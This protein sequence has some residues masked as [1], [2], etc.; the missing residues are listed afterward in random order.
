MLCLDS[1]PQLEGPLRQARKAVGQ[2]GGRRPLDPSFSRDVV[3]ISEWQLNV[4][5]FLLTSLS[6]FCY[7]TGGGG[8]LYL[9]SIFITTYFT[10]EET[11]MNS[12]IQS[13][14][15][16]SSSI[17]LFMIQYPVT[18]HTH[19]KDAVL[20]FKSL[21]LGHIPYCFLKMCA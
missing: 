21:K 11:S 3:R 8:M 7:S 5:Q 13:A 17:F 14:S 1:L 19:G 20:V 6:H 10:N 9:F 4:R 2:G 16:H 18:L 15:E 12:S